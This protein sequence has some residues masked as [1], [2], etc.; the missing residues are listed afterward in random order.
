MLTETS[1]HCISLI[2]A[3]RAFCGFG[4]F[5]PYQ[6]LC[7]PRL[8][9]TGPT[10]SHLWHP[11]GALTSPEFLPAQPW[12]LKARKAAERSAL[13]DLPQSLWRIHSHTVLEK[14]SGVSS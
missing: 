9:A 8:G 7:Q 3:P 5:T 13:P 4:C 1:H 11:W 10:C 14:A 6:T 2:L 12:L